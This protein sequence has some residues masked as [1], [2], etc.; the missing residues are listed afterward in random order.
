MSRGCSALEV[1]SNRTNFELI[2]IEFFELFFSFRINQSYI[3]ESNWTNFERIQHLSLIFQFFFEFNF[4]SVIFENLYKCTTTSVSWINNFCS[5]ASNKSLENIPSQV[6]GPEKNWILSH[7]ET[8]I[9]LTSYN[10]TF[11][12]LRKRAQER[13]RTSIFR[14][15]YHK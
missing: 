6:H 8:T 13:L 15:H 12:I 2:F 4:G 5:L 11:H 9:C 3:L 10:M 14:L 1:E 7:W